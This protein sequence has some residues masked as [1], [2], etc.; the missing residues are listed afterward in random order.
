MP[1]VHVKLNPG[2]PWQ[3]K[4]AFNKKKTVF[5]SKFDLNL[6]KNLEKCCFW[7]TAFYDVETWKSG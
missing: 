5:S 2:L 1:E 4:T 6:R 3:K 7:S